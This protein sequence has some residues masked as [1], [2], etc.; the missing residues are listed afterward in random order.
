MI[1]V[2]VGGASGCGVGRTTELDG[3]FHDGF[4]LI[5][6]IIMQRSMVDVS[7]TSV[8][9]LAL[10]MGFGWS[11]LAAD[12]LREL[13]VFFGSGEPVDNEQADADGQEEPAGA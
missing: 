7:D 10:L 1:V 8:T 2:V 4:E 9:R 5:G 13:F 11:H 3:L 6:R 12:V